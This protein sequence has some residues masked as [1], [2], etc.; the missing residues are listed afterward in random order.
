ME[1]VLSYFFLIVVPSQSVELQI[2]TQAS[3]THVNELLLTVG[4]RSEEMAAL[5][6]GEIGRVRR[7]EGV[8]E[9]LAEV[10]ENH[11]QRQ[12]AVAVSVD[13]LDD[14]EM[15]VFACLARLS[16]VRVMA[17]SAMSGS[18][19][20][21]RAIALGAELPT[22]E[23]AAGRLPADEPADEPGE[24]VAADQEQIIEPA[25]SRHAITPTVEDNLAAKASEPH[26]DLP[27]NEPTGPERIVDAAEVGRAT[28]RNR[29][30]PPTQGR[31]SPA[32]DRLEP[33]LTK[34]ELDALL[35]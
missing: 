35:G 18:A 19:K 21:A 20:L 28:A 24:M 31:F 26:V 7:Y 10:L 4:G 25:E 13:C 8:Y 3:G 14:R 15:Q 32:A 29:R 17:F 6:G 2:M 22:A 34:E 27:P 33:I 11:R 23:P 5:L 16:R 12:V 30:R 9:A 1:C